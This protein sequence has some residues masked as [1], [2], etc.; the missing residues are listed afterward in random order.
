MN[1]QKN[2]QKVVQK[3]N[4]ACMDMLSF[5][6]DKFKSKELFVQ[7]VNDVGINQLLDD[8]SQEVGDNDLIDDSE[9]DSINR[10]MQ[11]EEGEAEMEEDSLPEQ[12]ENAESEQEERDW[13]GDSK[14]G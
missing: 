8:Q 12:Q 3:K 10:Q 2:L 7:M 14:D 9:D 6:K 1:Q 13:D 5:F 11:D 4:D